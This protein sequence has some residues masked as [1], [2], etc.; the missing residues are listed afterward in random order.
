MNELDRLVE[1]MRRKAKERR[2]A[3]RAA[4]WRDKDNRTEYDAERSGYEV[5]IDDMLRAVCQIREAE[6]EESAEFC[7]ADPME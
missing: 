6:E 3:N 2:E 1:L 7:G 5:A 4:R